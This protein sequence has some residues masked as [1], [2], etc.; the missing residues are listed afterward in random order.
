M[1]QSKY[2]GDESKFDR[3]LSGSASN[4]VRGG[5][6]AAQ[7]TRMLRQKK[8]EA[9]VFHDKFQSIV[10]VGGFDS[11]DDPGI[12]RIMTSFQ[13]KNKPDPNT[14]GQTEVLT[15]ETL[16]LPNEDPAKPPRQVWVFDNMPELIE[17]PRVR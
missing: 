17:V 5:E 7:L 12:Q 3:E 16:S 10:T 13:A 15:P 9:Y 1:A 6:D 14:N 8:I 2:R 4:I 11:K